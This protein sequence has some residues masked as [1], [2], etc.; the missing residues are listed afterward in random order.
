MEMPQSP[1]TLAAR[2]VEE[3]NGKLAD[4]RHNINNCLSL[5]TAA[6]EIVSRK[7]D[8]APRMITNIVEQPQRIVEE[9]DRF[10]GEFE[11]ALG[12][13]RDP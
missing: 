12:I 8:S 1:V 2:E 5:I 10:T 9:L 7:P 13:K 6:A 4:L 11:K 3:L